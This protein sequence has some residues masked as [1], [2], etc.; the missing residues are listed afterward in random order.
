M[1]NSTV[2][3]AVQETA[4]VTAG[5]SIGV[6]ANL[7]SGIYI[8]AG[9]FGAGNTAGVG[10][11]VST[12]VLQNTIE[13]LVK[14]GAMLN[15]SGKVAGLPADAGIQVPNRAVRRRGIV[16][17]ASGT[18][19][20]LMIS[21]SGAAAGNGAGA[22]VINTLVA[23]NTVRAKVDGSTLNA[24]GSEISYQ[25]TAEDG[26]QQKI[27]TSSDVCVEASD[28]ALILD[29]AGGLAAG[30]TAGV[31]ATVVVLVFN[32]TVEAALSGT[33]AAA[34][35]ISVTANAEDDLYLLALA[36]GA[37]G[38][39]GVAGGAN[40]L[41]FENSTTAALGG[42]VV[43]ANDVLVSATADSRLYN[44]AAGAAGGGTAAVTAVAV[45]TYFKNTTTAYLADVHGDR[46]GGIACDGRRGGACQL[47]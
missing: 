12:A 38:T 3:A 11:A 18:E 42:M 16:V 21:I 24:S 23:K 7:D 32:K 35:D 10:M 43:K 46:H 17:H 15:A 9:A 31:G 39:A 30:S 4:V 45:V 6:I 33:V 40:A 1:S 26:K 25:I 14:Q 28:E 22:G 8:A 27:T 29:L 20:M 13:A 2:R 19:D 5:D 41:V 34:G 44:I 47:L 36:F 37:G